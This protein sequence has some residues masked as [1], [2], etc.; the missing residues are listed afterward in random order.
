M[1][2]Q[3]YLKLRRPFAI[4]KFVVASMMLFF[5]EHFIGKFGVL[6]SLLCFLKIYH[7]Y[8]MIVT[9]IDEENVFATI[10]LIPANKVGICFTKLC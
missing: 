8:H 4:Y 1:Y 5:G 7:G 3:V 6:S 9:L 10:I 2:I